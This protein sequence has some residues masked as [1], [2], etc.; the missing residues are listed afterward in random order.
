[1]NGRCQAF[2]CGAEV[3]SMLEREI[4]ASQNDSAAPTVAAAASQ[5][6][7]R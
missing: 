4:R 7:H 2:F 6:S 1:M 3:Q 5:E